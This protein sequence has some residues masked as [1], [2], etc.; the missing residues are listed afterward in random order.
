MEIL[1]VFEMRAL[2]EWK[3]RSID[4]VQ[5]ASEHIQPPV[6]GIISVPLSLSIRP[7]INI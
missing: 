6:V 1:Y 2:C 5:S 7:A 3:V 4:K